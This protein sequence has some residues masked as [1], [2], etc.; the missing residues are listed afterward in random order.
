PIVIAEWNRGSGCYNGG[1]GG[2]IPAGAFVAASLMTMAELHP[3]NSSHNVIMSH[4][5]STRFQIWNESL[6]PKGPGV[7]LESYARLVNETPNKLA[8]TGTYVDTTA[9]DFH[10]IAGKSDDGSKVNLLV[11]YYD[12]S[13]TDCPDNTNVGT[14]VPLDVN[15][16]NLPWGDAAFTWERWMHTSN[17]ALTL[18]DSGSGAGGSFSTSQDMRANVLELYLLAEHSCGNG[19]VG[20]GESCD[21]GAANGGF[22]SCCTKECTFKP[23]G[24]ASCDANLCTTT[25]TCTA[26]V[27]TAGPCREGQ[28]C[29]GC[30]GQCSTAATGCSCVY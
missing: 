29:S 8:T 15:V 14:I 17:S 6:A 16:N 3:T 11:S 9:I 7:G 10:A 27:C 25:D 20:P 22:A 19:T 24:P 26:G 4:L 1:T 18:V 12:V 2:T 21:D 13:D 23:D 30:G 28:A 5:F